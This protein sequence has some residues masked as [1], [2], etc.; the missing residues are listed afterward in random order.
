MRENLLTAPGILVTWSLIQVL[1]GPNVF[2]DFSDQMGN[3]MSPMAR[4]FICLPGALSL[5]VGDI[6]VVKESTIGR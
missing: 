4:F 1:Y 2:F 6:K 3:G 5:L